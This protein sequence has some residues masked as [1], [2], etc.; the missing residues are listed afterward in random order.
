MFLCVFVPGAS[1]FFR[2][3]SRTRGGAHFSTSAAVV[4]S[5]REC[6]F[7]HAND[8]WVP[9]KGENRGGL[10]CIISVYTIFII[11]I[12]ISNNLLLCIYYCCVCI[13]YYVCMNMEKCVVRTG[14]MSERPDSF[15]SVFSVINMAW[16]LQLTPME[17]WESI[18]T[19]PRP[20]EWLH[21][22]LYVVLH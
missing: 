7:P 1:M 17:V 12:I 14:R 18:K 3:V 9:E 8:G 22:T 16:K 15:G 19:G 6:T 5:G 4:F 2:S 20:D 11:T 10:L 13:I 21:V